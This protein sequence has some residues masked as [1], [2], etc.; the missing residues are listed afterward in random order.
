M[1]NGSSAYGG[2]CNSVTGTDKP[3]ASCLVWWVFPVTVWRP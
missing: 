1:L 2:T 3:P